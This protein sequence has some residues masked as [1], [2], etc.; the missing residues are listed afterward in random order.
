MSQIQIYSF[1][2]SPYALKVRCYLLFLG[3]DF[4]TFLLSTP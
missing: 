2:L 1:A 4:E 3:V